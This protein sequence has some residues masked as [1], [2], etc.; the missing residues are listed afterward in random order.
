MPPERITL[1]ITES[2]MIGDAERTMAMLTRLKGTGVQ[3]AID[4]FGTGY[5]SLGYLKRFPIDELKIDRLFVRDIDR[6]P[7]DAALAAAII[8]IG[9]SLGLC[10]VGEG[11]ETAA[12]LDTLASHGC[13]FVQGFHFSPPVAAEAFP[14]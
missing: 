8:S 5:S 10:V 6:N 2:S 12:Q 1:E 3:L 9:H 13:D 11:V 4:D 7:R 14:A